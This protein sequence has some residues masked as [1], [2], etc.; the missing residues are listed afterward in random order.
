MRYLGLILSALA[1]FLALLPAAAVLEIEDPRRSVMTLFYL[2]I[3]LAL[4]LSFVFSAAGRAQG[5]AMDASGEGLAARLQTWGFPILRRHGWGDFGRLY[6]LLFLVFMG[7]IL[8]ALFVVLT[9]TAFIGFEQRIDIQ[10]EN[11]LQTPDALTEE[12]REEMLERPT[13]TEAIRDVAS[14]N[15]QLSSGE[16]ERVAL[17]DT[18]SRIAVAVGYVLIFPCFARLVPFYFWRS[19]GP[20]AATFAQTWRAVRWR[21]AIVF[22]LIL[23]LGLVALFFLPAPLWTR[24]ALAAAFFAVWALALARQVGP[25]SPKAEE[26][27]K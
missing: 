10:D 1:L 20:E 6:A 4:F 23:L 24:Y 5:L 12:E 22:G 18:I 11:A 19:G 13:E 7:P 2:S 26:A 25:F 16:E 9:S 3:V 15:I 8:F 17:I 27:L 14:G 21:T